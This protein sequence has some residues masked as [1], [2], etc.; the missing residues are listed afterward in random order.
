MQND[1]NFVI[2]GPSNR[3]LWALNT[4]N[5]GDRMSKQLDGNLVVYNGNKATWACYF[6]K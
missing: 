4:V 2:Y 5:N 6:T 1:C 3:S